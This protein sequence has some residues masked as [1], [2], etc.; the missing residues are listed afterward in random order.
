M[1]ISFGC[2]RCF[3]TPVVHTRSDAH[4]CQPPV[5]IRPL[6]TSL[7]SLRK[8]TFLC[9]LIAMHRMLHVVKSLS[10]WKLHY[11]L[12][13][14]PVR[15]LDHG[16][17]PSDVRLA[18]ATMRLSTATTETVLAGAAL[19]HQYYQV[20]YQINPTAS[21]GAASR[22]HCSRSVFDRPTSA[23]LAFGGF[24]GQALSAGKCYR[25]LR[26]RNGRSS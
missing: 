9:R 17:R 1:S 19:Q 22:R 16:R 15:M 20:R 13:D 8:G 12:S 4:T 3:R 7:H 21:E 14:R 26:K 10:L 25:S 23:A 2:F 18:A 5:F 11:H 6:F 24:R